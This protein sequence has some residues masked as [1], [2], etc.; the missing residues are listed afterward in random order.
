M[1]TTQ[2]CAS[3]IHAKN[4][5]VGE[6]SCLVSVSFDDLDLQPSRHGLA[7]RAAASTNARSSGQRSSDLF[8]GRGTLARTQPKEGGE[9][10]HR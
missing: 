1:W 10:G 5:Q 6:V 8:V 4:R 7:R 3:D 2:R 9:P